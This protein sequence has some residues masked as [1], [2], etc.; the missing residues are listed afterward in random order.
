M[1]RIFLTTMA[2]LLVAIASETVDAQNRISFKKDVQLEVDQ[3]VVVYGMR[4][5]CS[6]PRP[7]EPNRPLPPESR[8][9]KIAERLNAKTTLGKFSFGKIG[10]RWSGRCKGDVY[11]IETIFTATKKGQEAVE[12]YGD[13][14]NITVK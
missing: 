1:Q 3:S 8:L 10:V 11:A 2:G 13:V 6:D 14:V 12:L 4:A 5:R 9:A 7:P